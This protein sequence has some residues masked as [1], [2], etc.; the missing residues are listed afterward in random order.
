M[1]TTWQAFREKFKADYVS[2][3]LETNK[4]TALQVTYSLDRFEDICRPKSLSG[5]KA[6]TFAEFMAK[7]REKVSAGTVGKDLDH[8]RLALNF[9]GLNE[10]AAL[11]PRIEDERRLVRYVTP[12]HFA[13]MFAAA[14]TAEL[15]TPYKIVPLSGAPITVTPGDWWRALLVMAASTGFF[16][17][18]LLSLA[19]SDIDMGTGEVTL[20]P[21]AGVKTRRRRPRR[22][23]L[24]Q[25]AMQCLA[26][27]S[28]LRS[29]V[30]GGAEVFGWPSEKADLAAQWRKDQ[31]GDL[32]RTWREIQ[33]AA[34]IKLKCHRDHD[35]NEACEIYSLD[36]LRAAAALHTRDE[37]L[38][39]AASRLSAARKRR[40]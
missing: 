17:K 39:L 36:E 18:E 4:D 11:V 8:I 38:A 31:R 33:K 32:W 1:L 34:G 21:P 28:P 24:P 6:R 2:P 26:K 7:R 14:D 25:L 23:K 19:W 9:V 20:T 13:A 5:I 22:A 29:P 37:M 35:H 27:L 12:E 10:L 15:P 3:R 40:P 16:V 30:D